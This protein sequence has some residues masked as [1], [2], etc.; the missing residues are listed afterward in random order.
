MPELLCTDLDRTLLPNGEQAESPNAR[1][2]L[3]QLIKQSG[4]RLAYVSGRDLGLVQ[5][6]IADYQLPA[7]DF[8]ITD[9]GS[10]IYQ[11]VDD[12]Y[13]PL[14]AWVSYLQAGWPEQN[15]D[16]L[17]RE[18]GDFAKLTLQDAARQKP[19]KLSYQVTPASE[20]TN[21]LGIL[22]QRLAS[23]PYAVNVVSSID[24][25]ADQGL[26]DLLPANAGKRAAID[27]LVT[28]LNLAAEQVFFSGDSGNDLD[29]LASPYPAVVVKN[30]LPEVVQQA[31]RLSKH[32]HVEQQLWVAQGDAS[33][34]LNG[35]YSA[36]IIEGL[37]HFYPQL[38]RWLT[39]EQKA[40]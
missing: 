8:A 32:Q 33:L 11:R 29:V 35:N 19:F 2:M 26:V 28:E 10:M 6:A 15:A 9:V 40:E 30:A 4:M 20:L 39:V 25:T 37:L 38:R 24:E 23:V 31:K 5:Q 34:G 18:L 7:P 12:G 3:A 22:Q 16:W 13:Q 14:P 27:F 1:A 21:E 36:G 17:A